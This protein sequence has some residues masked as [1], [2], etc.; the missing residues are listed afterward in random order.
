MLGTA[1]QDEPARVLPTLWSTGPTS[2]WWSSL[3]TALASGALLV[4]VAVQ[5]WK[6]RPESGLRHAVADG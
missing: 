3:I 5:L 1:T 2:D 4:A 6:A